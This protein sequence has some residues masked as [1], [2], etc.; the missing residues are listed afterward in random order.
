MRTKFSFCVIAYLDDFLIIENSFDRCNA[1]L[2]SLI[3]VL[4]KLGFSINYKKVKGP[5]RS[6]IFLGVMIDTVAYTLSLPNEKMCEFIDQLWDFRGRRRASKRQLES[7]IGSLNWAGQVIQGGRTYLRRM[8]DMK[9]KLCSPSDKIR[10]N[11]NF[12]D[13]LN[14]WLAYMKVFNGFVRILDKKNPCYFNAN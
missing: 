1:A 9:N 2:S 13:D 10:L 4:R 14:W 11:D 8:I 6:L 7:L 5:C 3:Q 12:F